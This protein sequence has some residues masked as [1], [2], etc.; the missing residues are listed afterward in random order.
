MMASVFTKHVF[1]SITV[2]PGSNDESGGDDDSNEP[3][4]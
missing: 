1:G 2:N 4:K 3:N